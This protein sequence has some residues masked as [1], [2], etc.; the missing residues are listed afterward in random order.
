[1]D[2]VYS[3]SECIVILFNDG[4]FFYLKIWVDNLKALHKKVVS[5][6]KV[7]VD[8]A[9]TFQQSWQFNIAHLFVENQISA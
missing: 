3:I 6:R 9:G 7:Q 5:E 4:Q 2:K 8:L 1:M